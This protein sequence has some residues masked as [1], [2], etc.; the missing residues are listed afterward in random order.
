MLSLRS[1]DPPGRHHVLLA[2]PDQH[3]PEVGGRGNVDQ[4]GE[5]SILLVSTNPSA[6]IGLTK[7]EAP[8]SVLT[9]SGSGRVSSASAYANVA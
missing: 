1:G 4:A 6:V 7:L 9:S 3:L 2:D 5:P 8:C